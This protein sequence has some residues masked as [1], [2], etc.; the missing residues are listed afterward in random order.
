MDPLN[1][2]TLESGRLAAIRH[3]GPYNEIGPAFRELGKI[4]GQAGLFKSPGAL[5]VGVY[6]DDPNTT[7]ASKLRS[8]AGVTI[9]ADGPVPPG[10]VEEKIHGGEFAMTTHVGPYDG[11][12]DAWRRASETVAGSGRK[13][14]HAASYE[15]Y[16]ND[17]TQVA[18]AELKTEIWIPIEE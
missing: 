15:I 10:L 13:R 14:R 11:L 1:V 9:P 5:M 17:P 7:D 4:A 12:P 8:A 2:Q 6:H 3:T 16:L 18:E